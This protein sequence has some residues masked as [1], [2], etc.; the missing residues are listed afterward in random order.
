MI[1]AGSLRERGCHTTLQ[2]VPRFLGRLQGGHELCA[3]G[4][5]HRKMQKRPSPRESYINHLREPEA[6][7]AGSVL[8]SGQSK[9][10]TRSESALLNTPE[11]AFVTCPNGALERIR[12]FAG[13]SAA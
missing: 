5:Y 8:R 11:G 2:I 4:S 9:G 7:V 3:E 12:S 6:V 13:S 10:G 1:Q